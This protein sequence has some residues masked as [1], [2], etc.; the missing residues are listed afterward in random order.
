[1][2]VLGREC[3]A[4]NYDVGYNQKNDRAHVKHLDP[5]SIM[6][7]VVIVCVLLTWAKWL[8]CIARAEATSRYHPLRTHFT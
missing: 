3:E 1:M 6:D 2:H 5:V 7:V 8:T 4:W